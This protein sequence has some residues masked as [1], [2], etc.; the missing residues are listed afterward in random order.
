MPFYEI[1]VEMHGR[2]YVQAESAEAAY[3]NVRH[4]SPAE[5]ESMTTVTDV[6]WMRDGL[7]EEA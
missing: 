2:F 3:E 5:I 4:W 1:P 6:D 7:P